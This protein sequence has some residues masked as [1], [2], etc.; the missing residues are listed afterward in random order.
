VA[1]HGALSSPDRGQLSLQLIKQ[2][3]E[4]IDLPSLRVA[5]SRFDRFIYARCRMILQNL[6]F[7]AGERG[8]DSL[9]LVEHVNAI[10]IFFEHTNDAAYLTLDAIE[11]FDCGFRF[12]H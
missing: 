8:F 2:I 7:G 6:T 9:H 5:I 10:A 11:T 12:R 3:N 1:Y 4:L